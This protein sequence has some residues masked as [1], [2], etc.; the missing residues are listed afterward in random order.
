MINKKIPMVITAITILTTSAIALVVYNTVK[1]PNTT[2]NQENKKITF[3]FGDE[4]FNTQPT[5]KPKTIKIQSNPFIIPKRITPKRNQPQDQQTP[6]RNPQ[7][8]TSATIK[9]DKS[10]AFATDYDTTKASK[11]YDLARVITSN[12]YINAVLETAVISEIP[13]QS[14]VAVIENN[15]YGF[16]PKDI[17]LPKGSKVQGSLE[18]PLA[19][20]SRRLTIIWN[21]IITP[22]GQII[23]LESE[24]IDSS[25]VSGLKGKLDNRVK[26]KYGGALMI[27]ALN[28]FANL[29]VDVASVRQQALVQ[30]ITNQ[31][32]P[33]TNQMIR[34][35][36][37]VKPVI[38]I[39]QGE[40]IVITPTKDIFFPK[41]ENQNIK[42]I[43]TN[44]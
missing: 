32:A 31:L 7:A 34:E 41:S 15:I 28:T 38:S 18:Q 26:D 29:S 30:S 40:R 42:A 5:I 14:I 25:G 33:L 2:Q 12:K 23:E 4:F 3:V 6:K 27:S 1:K 8:F 10:N 35:N 13:T 19:K 21:R 43:F 11:K 16:Q 20:H 22:Q 24:S 39:R 17:L 44:K 36:M 37:D 9:Y